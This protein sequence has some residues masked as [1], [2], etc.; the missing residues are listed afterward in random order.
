M[1][2]FAW[3]GR[4][5]VGCPEMDEDHLPM[6]R[7]L[8]SLHEAMV[9]GRSGGV[10]GKVLRELAEHEAAHF[11]REEALMGCCRY[12]GLEEHYRRHQ[13]LLGE[14][15]EL[16]WRAAAGHLPIAYDTMQTMRRWVREHMNGDDRAAAQFIVA[17]RRALLA[18]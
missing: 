17:A 5:L 4:N 7:L 6:L 2:L 18:R 9:R 3:P 12:P 8:D 15:E 13:Q 1:G 11:A 10:T 14:L 16:Q